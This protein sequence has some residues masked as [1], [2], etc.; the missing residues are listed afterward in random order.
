MS[1]PQPYPG[2]SGETASPA[3][4]LGRH[5]R[6][7]I[8]LA[9]VGITLLMLLLGYSTYSIVTV[10][11]PDRG[12]VFR[13]GVAGQPQYL[14]PIWCQNDDVDRDLCTL[15]YRG[16]TRIDKTGR[17]VPDLAEGW[18]ILDDKT[19]IFRLKPEQFWHDGR[20]VTVDDVLFTVGVLQDPSLLDT[21]G[22]P[23]FWRNVAVEKVDDLTVKF[24][25]PQPFA[26]FLDYTSIGL[27]PQHIYAD[28][29]PKELVT[30]PLNGTPIGAGPMRVAEIAA[31]HIRLEPSAF[32]AG[33]TPYIS[34]LEFNFYPD[35]PSVLAAFEAGQID[36]ISRVLPADI[37]AATKRDDL[38]LFSSV[39]SGYEDILLNLN[40]PNTPFFQ[41]KRV[42]QAL[43]HGIDREG[44]VRDVLA[45]QGVV[46]HSLLTPDN[47]AY[48]PDVK[49]YGHDP[50]AAQ[51]L[52]DEAGWRDSDGD[53]VRDK[54]GKA[55]AFVLLV[56]DDTMHKQIGERVG[57]DWAQIGVRAQVTPVSFSGMVAD[58]LMPRSYEAVLTDWDQV[59]DPDPYPQWH[60]SQIS[61]GGQN[62]SGWQNPE[63]DKLMEDA[64]ATTDENQ[65]R[66]LYQQIQA[67]FAEELPALPVFY[68]VY[69][70]GVSDRV[71]NVQI[72]SL[73]SPAE[74]FANFADWYIDSRRVPAN[75]VPSDAPPTPPGAAPAAESSG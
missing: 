27:L 1:Q 53:G 72:G 50:A 35:Y 24:T 43:M 36:G 56:K 16:L 4:S 13:E 64:R 37:A 28:T 41:D 60:S 57:A 70:Y 61:G 42:R 38:Q 17:I 7:L 62:Y 45:N 59:G 9:L 48:N 12:G 29:P 31:D 14:N 67:I 52:L 3:E 73:N 26:P 54:D 15:I 71:H 63:A 44:I 30:K 65:R 75:Q 11:V 40:N 33:R 8:A 46:A 47:W 23:S 21:P 66:A 10:L 6:W 18:Q 68:P 69:T 58:F 74:R 19:Y 5:L 39:E 34:T 51:Q 32:S 22:L 20:A 55:L 2:P 49:Q 25:L